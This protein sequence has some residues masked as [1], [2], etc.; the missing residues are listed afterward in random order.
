MNPY[1]KAYIV[2]FQTNTQ[3]CQDTKSGE[4][5]HGGSRSTHRGN[6]N[7]DRGNSPFANSSLVGKL[8]K[9]RI[10]HLSITKGGAWFTQLNKILEAI[11]TIYQD[12]Q[13]DYIPDTISFNTKPTQE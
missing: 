8:T 13:Y 3:Q 9:N 4:P 5:S 12:K 2:I 1:H 6:R 10:S 11:S 7:G